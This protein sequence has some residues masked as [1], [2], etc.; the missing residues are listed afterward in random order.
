MRIANQNLNIIPHIV[1]SLVEVIISPDFIKF[2]INYIHQGRILLF[3][4]PTSKTVA[5]SKDHIEKIILYN[6]DIHLDIQSYICNST[7]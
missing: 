5:N 2:R 3:I 1:F 7:K 6:T 4:I